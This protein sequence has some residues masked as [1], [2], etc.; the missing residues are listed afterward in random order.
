MSPS[1]SRR[2]FLQTSAA[3]S[4]VFAAPYYVPAR[5]FGANERISIGMIGVKNRGGETQNL[6]DFRQNCVAVCDVDQ[7]VAATAA[8]YVV[9][10]GNKCD[11]VGDYR[12]LLDRKD[13]DAVVIST[14][15]HWHA[16]MTIDACQA[17]KDVFC[18]K[19]LSLFVSEG[20]KMVEAAR[21]HERI[22][23][24]GSQ[25][26]S[27]E[28][29][30]TA[31]ELVRNGALGKLQQ[32]LVGIPKPNHAA[33]WVP[34]SPPP[35]ELDYDFWLGPAPERP[36][37]VNRVHYNFRF[38][39]DYSGG[40]M[41]NFGAHHLDIAQWALG[42]DDSGPISAEGIATYPKDKRLCEV[43][44]TCRVTLTYANGVQVIVGQEQKDIPGGCTF[45]GEKGRMFVDRKQITASDP[46][47]LNTQL[48]SDA[49]RLEVSNN[50]PRN[51]LECIQSRELPVA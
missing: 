22:V 14:P 42:M 16:R 23:Q 32:V 45:V 30:R 18:E 15:D 31:C 11:I 8:K 3:A 12:K 9:A 39:W 19:P 21:K 50:H 49:V 6:K 4:A 1:L 26:R 35:S 41:T 36:Y 7:N 20:R 37:N 29:F 25:Q 44:Q 48:A 5:V 28:R 24:T 47:V 33:K 10:G 40:Q 51:W 38:F 43:T 17:G 2:R 13:I 27:D 34:D 46:A